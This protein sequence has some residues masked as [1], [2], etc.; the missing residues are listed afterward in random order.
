MS[1]AAA[2]WLP[3]RDAVE[4]AEPRTTDVRALTIRQPW[5]ACIASGAKTVENRTWAT[6]HRGRLAIHAGAAFDRNPDSDAPELAHL[7]RFVIKAYY[8]APTVLRMRSAIVAV[9]DL[10]DCHPY[11]PGCCVSPW[12][13]KSDGVWHW[14]IGSI[15]ALSRPVPCRGHLGLWRLPEDVLASVMEQLVVNP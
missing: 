6:K 3:S 1:F 9:G 10:D 12:A 13:E 8:E 5:A 4:S 11:E 14:T 7:D 2:F 15:R